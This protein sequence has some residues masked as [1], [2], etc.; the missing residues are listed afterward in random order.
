MPADDWWEFAKNET[1]D[2]SVLF[3]GPILAKIAKTRPACTNLCEDEILWFPRAKEI[4]RIAMVRMKSNLTDDLWTL[5]PYYSRLSAAE[6]RMTERN[7]R[8]S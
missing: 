6:E 8:Q 4:A 3:T 2:D 1:K 5:T 7:G